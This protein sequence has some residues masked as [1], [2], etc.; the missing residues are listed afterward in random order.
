MSS[1]RV[2]VLLIED[3]PDDIL[4]LQKILYEI[5]ESRMKVEVECAERIERGLA[6]ISKGGVDIA[7]LDLSLPD[8]QGLDTFNQFHSQAPDVPIIVL[9]GLPD[10]T[11]AIEAV[12][13]GAQDYFLKQ[14]VDSKM[15]ARIIRYA[16]ERN[17]MR[18]E[19]RELSLTDELTGLYNRRGFLT[20]AE[21][22]LKLARRRKSSF[23]II[24]ADLDGLK[25]I[26]DTFGHSEGDQALFMVATLMKRTFRS[27]DIL[28]RY[29]GDEFVVLAIDADE[30]NV[31]I[32]V[33][34]LL[35]RTLEH[36]GEGNQRYKLSLSVG[37]SCYDPNNESSL[38]E[39]VVHADKVLY[40]KKR[41]KKEEEA[42]RGS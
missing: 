14:E 29:G 38:E 23:S 12:R 42:L 25:K 31:G 32:L 16:I 2:K 34:R 35:Q 11:V 6:R 8:S 9:S 15:L 13:Q 1:E 30:R 3:D 33:D 7:L 17:R 10:D 22:C 27:S 20:H 19:L 39:L 40:E 4:L 21:Q 5:D 28:A 24:L 36:N 18:L 41:K 37:C 26:N